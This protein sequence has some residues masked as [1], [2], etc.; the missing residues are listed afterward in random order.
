MRVKIIGTGWLGRKTENPIIRYRDIQMLFSRTK[1]L[2]T[3]VY[4]CVNLVYNRP[5]G[6]TNE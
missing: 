1:N 3:K 4:K 2:H 6:E 5:E